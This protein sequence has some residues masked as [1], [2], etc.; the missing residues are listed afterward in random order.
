MIHLDCEQSCKAQTAAYTSTNELD[1]LLQLKVKLKFIDDS[2]TKII[3][4]F[5]ELQP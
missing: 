5:V 1:N 2:D 3:R 4:H